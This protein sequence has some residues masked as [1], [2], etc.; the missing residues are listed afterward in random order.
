MSTLV[1][2][3]IGIH[4]RSRVNLSVPEG[5]KERLE[6]LR[7]EKRS[8]SINAVVIAALQEYLEAQNI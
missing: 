5:M 3:N 4:A 1:S 2:E 6:E 8:R 7:R